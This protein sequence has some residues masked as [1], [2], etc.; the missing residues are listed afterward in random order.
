MNTIEQ[1]VEALIARLRMMQSALGVDETCGEAADALERLTA[2]NL[3]LAGEVSNRNSRALAGDTATKQ[4]DA[5]YEEIER[6]TAERDA[7][8]EKINTLWIQSAD[9]ATK[10]DSLTAELAD[11]TSMYNRCVDDVHAARVE[12]NSLREGLDGWHARYLD[13]EVEF[14]RLVD[15]C[16]AAKLRLATERDALRADAELKYSAWQSPHND[17]LWFENPA[18]CEIIDNF[19]PPVHVGFEYELT[20]G[21]YTTQ[22]YRVVKI[23]DAESDDVLVELI[24]GEKT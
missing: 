9:R 24:A 17:D 5:M 11:V 6:L 19:H 16:H 4:F 13:A 21:S 8:K 14:A 22:R 20:A 10:I 18:D 2:E 23:A 1:L 7:A 3:R 15:V 12:R